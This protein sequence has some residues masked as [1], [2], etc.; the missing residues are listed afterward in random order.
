MLIYSDILVT[1]RL[2][3]R[4]SGPLYSDVDISDTSSQHSPNLLLRGGDVMGTPPLL[5]TV[6]VKSSILWSML[7]KELP[8]LYSLTKC[9]T[10]YFPLLER[11][12]QCRV[13]S[14]QRMRA[15]LLALLP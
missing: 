1:G 3:S 12:T 9:L 14:A 7:D 15:G 6:A 11:L 2:V 5:S 13:P 8:F 10:V 4:T